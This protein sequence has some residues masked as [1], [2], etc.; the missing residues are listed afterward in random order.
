MTEPSDTVLRAITDDGAFRVITARTT[1][2]VRGAVEAQG[3]VGATA[4]HFGDLLTGS[5]LFRET[6]APN[7]RVQG[8][9]KGSNGSGSVIADSHPSGQTRGLIQLKGKAKEIEL[10]NGAVLQLM[11][12]LPNGRINQGIV[13]VP[14]DGGISHSFMAY[15]Q[16]SEQVVSMIAVGTLFDGDRVVSAG[17]Y[18]V[19]L[20]PEAARGPLMVMTERLR[21]F[22]SIDPQLGDS[23]FT[24]TWLLD[25]LLYGMPFTRLEESPVRFECWCDEVRVVSA[26][27]SLS[28]GD[29]EHLLS[30]NDVLEI[31]CEYCKRDFRIAP[32]RLRGLLE[33]S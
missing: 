30:T 20:L 17:G 18:M 27:A 14:K 5:I 3:V 25:E 33:Q 8:I 2:T 9:I 19:Q 31:A 21:E 16:T 29:L 15:L 23:A 10:G 26:L 28:R 11:R 22:E 24:P 4:R 32:A 1:Q 13:E 7:L 6:M 12:S